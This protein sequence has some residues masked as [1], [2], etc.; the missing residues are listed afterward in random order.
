MRKLM[1]TSLGVLALS[2]L[3][4][5]SAHAQVNVERSTSAADTGC[6]YVLPTSVESPLHSSNPAEFSARK[7]TD[8]LLNT[9][10]PRA[11][12]GEHL[13]TLKLYT[14]KGYLYRQ[15]D[16]PVGPDRGRASQGRKVEHYPYPVMEQFPEV[17]AINGSKV[18]AVTIHLPVAGSNIITSS[19]YGKWTVKFTLDGQEP[20]CRVRETR[21]IVSE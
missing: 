2:L 16:V 13:L 9:V 10:F 21:F 12:D 19:L 18:Q 7:T 8:I 11:L 17:K 15:F 4:T 5:P 1:M 20:P 3:G 6:F 14:P